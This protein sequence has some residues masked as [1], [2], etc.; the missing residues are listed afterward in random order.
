MWFKLIHDKPHCSMQ[1]LYICLSQVGASG[2]LWHSCC[3]NPRCN[4]AKVKA[5]NMAIDSKQGLDK[6][7][8]FPNACPLV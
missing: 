8:K 6:L 7:S 4:H 2:P 3:L 5:R 1:P